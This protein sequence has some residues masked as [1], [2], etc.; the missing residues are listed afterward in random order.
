M[1]TVTMAI[2]KKIIINVSLS[3]ILVAMVSGLFGYIRYD[4]LSWKSHRAKEKRIMATLDYE[5]RLIVD[6][7]TLTKQVNKL[8]EALEKQNFDALNL[9]KML[10]QLREECKWSLRGL[11][12]KVNP[13]IKLE[14]ELKRPPEAS[15]KKHNQ[16]YLSIKEILRLLNE[17]SAKNNLTP[18]ERAQ[19]AQKLR[20]QTENVEIIISKL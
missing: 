20:E 14:K 3:L 15:L 10:N 18:E 4:Q 8:A 12:G 13:V 6:S 19:F 16:Y 17:I 11:S 2:F 7:K 5:R 1:R 9:N